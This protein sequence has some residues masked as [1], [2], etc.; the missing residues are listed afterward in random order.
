MFGFAQADVVRI[1]VLD[2][3]YPSRV[4]LSEPWSPE[5]WRGAPIR[6]FHVLID[7]P[8]DTARDFLVRDRP[9]LVARLVGGELVDVVP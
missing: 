7:A 6:F 3:R 5:P 8:H 4:V 2:P 1:A 9:H